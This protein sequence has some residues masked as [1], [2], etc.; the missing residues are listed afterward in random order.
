[1]NIAVAEVNINMREKLKNRIRFETLISDISTRFVKLPSGEVDSEVKVTRQ[2]V[3]GCM[4]IDF[5]ALWQISTDQSRA[6]FLLHH[7]LLQGLPL[8][9]KVIDVKEIFR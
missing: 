3:C 2:Q 7:Y 9:S 6:M 4:N 1:M 5:S 8:V